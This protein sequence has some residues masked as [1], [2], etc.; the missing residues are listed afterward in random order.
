MH[1]VVW[2]GPGFQYR[3]V[4]GDMTDQAEAQ[5]LNYAAELTK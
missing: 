4:L 1:K 2:L 5:D 3:F